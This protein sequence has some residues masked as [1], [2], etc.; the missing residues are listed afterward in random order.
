[1]ARSVSW[2]AVLWAV[3][4]LVLRVPTGHA[5][6]LGIG[7]NFTAGT[8]A[9]HSVAFPPDTM[10][11]VGQDHVVEELRAYAPLVTPGSYVV[12]EDTCVNGH[13]VLPDFG[14]GPM[15][16]VAEFLRDNGDFEVDRTKEKFLMTFNPGGFLKRVR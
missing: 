2:R 4:A 14:P 15:E 6:G 7:Q 16:A 10:G 3:L 1:M 8:Y 13:P 5:L 9:F 12:V 11:A